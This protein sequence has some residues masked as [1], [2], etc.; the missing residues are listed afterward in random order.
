M[1]YPAIGVNLKEPVFL[2]DGEPPPQTYGTCQTVAPSHPAL[3][4]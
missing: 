3:T 2:V 1:T 4:F